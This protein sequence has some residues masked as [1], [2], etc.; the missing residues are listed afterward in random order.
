MDG[1][2]LAQ[3]SGIWVVDGYTG[4][5]KTLALPLEAKSLSD[6]SQC[7]PRLLKAK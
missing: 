5:P 1:E 4:G 6:Q 3:I 7:I 2:V